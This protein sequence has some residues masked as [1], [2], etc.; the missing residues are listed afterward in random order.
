[1]GDQVV[2][3]EAS[4]GFTFGFTFKC[5]RDNNTSYGFSKGRCPAIM[6]Y[7]LTFLYTTDGRELW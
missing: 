2:C 4:Q 7:K 1:M 5:L 6:D 3:G